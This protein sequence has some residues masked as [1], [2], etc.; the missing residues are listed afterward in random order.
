VT[1]TPS[2][3]DAT[4]LGGGT[5]GFRAEP[6]VVRGDTS[7]LRMKAQKKRAEEQVAKAEAELLE[8]MHVRSELGLPLDPTGFADFTLPLPAT[9]ATPD[10]QRAFAQ[11]FAAQHP[12]KGQS[13]LYR[14]Y[15]RRRAENPELPKIPRKMFPIMLGLGRTPG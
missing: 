10:M 15:G 6:K 8:A 12:G 3:R 4:F 5:G 11:A 9:Q 1:N 14:E 13:W 7:F 2:N